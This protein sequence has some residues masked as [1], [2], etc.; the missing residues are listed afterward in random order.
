MPLL[1][2][3][4]VNLV[5]GLA[6][7]FAQFLT[8][9]VAVVSAALVALS[10]ITA[11]LLLVFNSAVSPLV[12]QLFAT[13]YGQFLGLAFPPVAGNCLVTIGTVWSACTL[14][15]WQAKALALAVQS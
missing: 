10:T 9:K 3:L 11:A 2:T 6:G 8:R 13:E 1:G 12:G 15:G 4:L 5:G 14:Y 7:F